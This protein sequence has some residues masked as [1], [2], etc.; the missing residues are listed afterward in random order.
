MV[1][2]IVPLFNKAPYVLR[3]LDSI[4][5]QTYTDFEVIVVDDGSTDG[6]EALVAAFDDP[7]VRLVKQSNAGPGAARNR[8]I[9]AARSTLLAFLDAD[10]EWQPTFLA[11]SLALLDAHPQAAAISSAAVRDPP[12]CSTVEG[13]RARGLRDGEQRLQSTA[14]L[15]FARDFLEFMTWPCACIMRTEVARRF[16]GYYEHH[17][18]YGEDSYLMLKILLAYPVVVNLE[19]LAVY[20]VD[21][22]GLNRAR[23]AL[24]GTEAFLQNPSQIY[25]VCPSELRPLLDQMLAAQ[26]R[27]TACVLTYWG[28]W[29][30]GRALIRRF[31]CAS[32]WRLPYF[33]PAL[34]AVNPLG[35]AASALWRGRTRNSP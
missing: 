18:T 7:R 11:R 4:A 29:R 25:D 35:A 20:H 12:G 21:A 16:G 3:A 22:S 28:A 6:G 8:G 23:K 31:P 32:P 30:E 19:P 5:R 24:R 14:P 15:A 26:A 33:L 9:A 13:W 1:S 34:I 2:V 10:D 17:S 27:K